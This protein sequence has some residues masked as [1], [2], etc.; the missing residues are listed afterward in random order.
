MSG[1]LISFLLIQR[2]IFRYASKAKFISQLYRDRPLNARDA[3]TYWVEYV[4]RHRG[5][6]HLRYPGADLN[7][8]QSNSV[9]VVLFL[10]AVAYIAI[11]IFVKIVKLLTS[12]ACKSGKKTIKSKTKAN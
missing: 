4:I 10:V 2:V 1:I 11:K 6:P 9:D 12:K 8:W 7:F 5:A 3:A